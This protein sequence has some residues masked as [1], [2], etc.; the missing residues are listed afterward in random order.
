MDQAQAQAQAQ[1]F[2]LTL[3]PLFLFFGVVMIAILIVPLW[4]IATK[5]GLAGP[6]SLLALIPGIGVLLTLYILAFSGGRVMPVQ[7]RSYPP[8]YPPQPT[9]SAQ[10]LQ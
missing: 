3:M 10:P 9:Y 4:R 8:G 6:I 5:A 7:I 1:H 2:F